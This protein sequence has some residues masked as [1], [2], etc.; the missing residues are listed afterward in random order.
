[1]SFRSVNSDVEIKTKAKNDGDSVSLEIQT[2]NVDFT[3]LDDIGY[4]DADKLLRDFDG[5]LN[6]DVSIVRTQ[7]RVLTGKDI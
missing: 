7:Y 4:D 2:F 6:L 5:S 1:M 3:G